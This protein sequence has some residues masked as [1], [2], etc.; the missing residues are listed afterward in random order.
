MQKIVL[1]EHLITLS[2]R[3][4]MIARRYRHWWRFYCS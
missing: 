1:Y 3:L 4:I 2:S